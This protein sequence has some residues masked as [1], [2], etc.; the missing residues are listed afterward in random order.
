MLPA[1]TART[2]RP[3]DARQHTWWHRLRRLGRWGFVGLGGGVAAPGV[4]CMLFAGVILYY[5]YPWS[6][7]FRN[8]ALIW[9]VSAPIYL[10]ACWWTYSHME[11]RSH[12]TLG[13][14][15]ANCGHELLPGQA[16]C[17]ECGQT[18]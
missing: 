12:A 5:G 6:T 1:L 2:T 10:A 18:V 14:R 16:R 17:P 11:E 4:T 15:C 13:V 7:F 3:I 8:G 9:F